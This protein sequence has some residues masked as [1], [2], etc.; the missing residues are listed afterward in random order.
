M[1]TG[2]VS[3]A[4]RRQVVAGCADALRDLRAV[5]FQ[6]GS[7][8]LAGLAGDLAELR[9]LAGAGLAEVVADAQTRGVIDASQHASTAAWVADV[10]WHSRREAA[11]MAKTASILTRPDLAAVADSI[12]QVDVDPGTAVVVAAEYDKITPDLREQA[13]P[14]VLEQFLTV[15]AEHGPAAARQLR[16]EILARYGAQGEFDEHQ[17]RC[18]RQIDLTA[19]RESSA[20]VWDYRLT[21][22]DEGRAVLEAAIGPLS[23]PKPH[24]ETGDRDTRPVGRRRGE[25]LIQALHRSVAAAAHVPTSS[26]AV[27]MLT[28]GLDDLVGRVGG[29]IVLGSRAAG[30]LI[31]PD[32]VRRLACDAAV[33]PVVLGRGGENLDQG[34]EQR[35]FTPAQVR[36]L[37]LR[38]GHC[39]FPGC[40]VPAAWADSHHLVHWADG[41]PTDLTNGA[42]LCPRHHTIAHRDLLAGVVTNNHVVWDLRPGTYRAP[43]RGRAAPASDQISARAS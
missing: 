30:T 15:A 14:A 4:D 17:E 21:L 39:T 13:K 11:T 16:K 25:A 38:D 40:T 41:G 24:P 22:D 34:R 27:L 9:A 8:E 36:A 35:L 32:T 18:R 43:P 10:A 2:A 33:I 6:C 12:R 42:L 23:A 28:M 19:G 5:L 31:A 29:A 20:G 3:L 1:A 37:W 7:G 26:K